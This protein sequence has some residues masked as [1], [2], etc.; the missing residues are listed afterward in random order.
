MQ[1]TLLS[2]DTDG[3]GVVEF[4]EVIGPYT[5]LDIIL[6]IPLHPA[7]SSTF[8]SALALRLRLRPLQVVSALLTPP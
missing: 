8:S 5:P 3:D 6:Y 4:H 7:L 2:W 1:T